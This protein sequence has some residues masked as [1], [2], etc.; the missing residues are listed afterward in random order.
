MKS[1]TFALLRLQNRITKNFFQ[2]QDGSAPSVLDVAQ[3][4][5][6]F[7]RGGSTFKDMDPF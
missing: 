5:I 4:S 7:F 2:C 1:L 3:A 6:D